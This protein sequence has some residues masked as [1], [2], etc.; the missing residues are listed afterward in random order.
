LRELLGMTED[1]FQRSFR[2]I[3]MRASRLL[4]HSLVIHFADQMNAGSLRVFEAALLC[5]FADPQVFSH[6][7]K[8]MTGFSP[9]ELVA[10]GG[11][12]PLVDRLILELDRTRS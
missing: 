12:E 1:A 7:V 8:S 6:H 10:L 9:S 5:G 11:S 4:A 2:R 3:G